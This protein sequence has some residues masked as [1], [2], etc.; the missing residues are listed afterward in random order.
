MGKKVR[1]FQQDFDVVTSHG[2]R[3]IYHDEVQI[4][5]R[6]YALMRLGDSV[7]VT[8]LSA[9]TGRVWTHAVSRL[10]PTTDEEG[11][12]LVLHNGDMATLYPLGEVSESIRMAVLAEVRDRNFCI[13]RVLDMIRTN[14]SMKEPSVW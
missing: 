8:A 13:N 5:S 7:L 11:L 6:V 3:L 10:A 12:V 4:I 2:G 14:P 9:N 1:R